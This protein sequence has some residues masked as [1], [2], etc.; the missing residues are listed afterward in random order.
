MIFRQRRV[1]SGQ[2]P[3]HWLVI[4][5][6]GIA[7]RVGC[8]AGRADD[9]TNAIR[10]DWIDNVYPEPGASLAVSDVVEVSHLVQ[11]HDEKVRLIVDGADVTA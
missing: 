11:R 4:V 5:L 8:E 1:T 7:A 3:R 6:I 2:M 10:P 9:S